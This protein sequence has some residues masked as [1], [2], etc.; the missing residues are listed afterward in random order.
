MALVSIISCVSLRRVT[1]R[2]ERDPTDDNPNLFL[3]ENPN[4]TQKKRKGTAPS[5]LR[6]S[7]RKKRGR[8]RR[9]GCKGF[10]LPPFPPP[11]LRR[12]RGC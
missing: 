1:A 12:E 11:R 6:R 4:L 7:V 8:R 9:G 10:A 5:L 3:L 2:K